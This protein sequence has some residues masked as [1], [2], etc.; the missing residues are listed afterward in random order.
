MVDLASVRV[1]HGPVVNRMNKKE[2]TPHVA[3]I[4]FCP[5]SSNVLCATGLALFKLYELDQEIIHQRIIHFRAEFYAFTC[6][7]W[8]AM[9]SILVRS[10]HFGY[11]GETFSFDLKAAT[12]HG[13]V[14]W[15]QDGSIRSDIS[16]EE[17]ITVDLHL[18]TQETNEG[19]IRS[20]YYLIFSHLCSV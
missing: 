6:H 18:S 7:C 17:S 13:H 9:N 1:V 14:F 8:L 4:S 16:L 10:I 3:F 11:L 12:E 20:R 19:R 2:I 15:I 5:F